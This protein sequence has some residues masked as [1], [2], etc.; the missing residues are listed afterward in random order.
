MNTNSNV[1]LHQGDMI[2]V[3]RAGVVYV[4]GEVAQPSGILMAES[5]EY[6]ALKALAMA[7][8]PTKLATLNKAMIVRRTP[9]GIKSIPVPLKKI[10]SSK[11]PDIAMQRDDILVVPNSLAKTAGYRGLDAAVSLA[12]S[13]ALVGVTRSTY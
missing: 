8:G 7:H 5:T 2:S 1:M 11:T 4:V 3:A 13:A 6:T 9:D 12:G 10:M